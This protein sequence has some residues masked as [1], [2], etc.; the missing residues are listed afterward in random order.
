VPPNTQ[1]TFDLTG[2]ALGVAVL[3]PRLLSL[4]N[5]TVLSKTTTTMR[6]RGTT[7]S[8]GYI[9]VALTDQADG[10]ENPYLKAAT[11]QQ[12]LA[13]TI[14]GSSL[15][16]R[17]PTMTQCPAGQTWDPAANVCKP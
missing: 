5:A 1:V 8:C 11:V 7:P 16:P 12:V 2:E 17:S 4:K 6:V 13:G 9:D 15:A 14:C 3:L 10:D